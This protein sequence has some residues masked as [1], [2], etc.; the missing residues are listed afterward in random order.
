MKFVPRTTAPSSTNKYYL[1]AGKGG[2]NR[3]MEINKTTHSCLPNCCGLVHGRWME[4]QGQTD[5]N[6]Y[7]K[8]STGDACN[9]YKR[10]DGYKRGQEPKLG[11]IGCYSGGKKDAGHVL[12]VEEIKSN[13]D[14]VTSNSAY[15]GT[16]FFM[17]TL[18]KKS[19]Y[20]Y[21]SIH[22]FQGFIYNPVEFNTNNVTP[23]V[24]R[25]ETKDQLKVLTTELR[26]RTDHN[27]SA[28]ILGVAQKDGIYNYY[29]TFKD[30]KY[31]WYRIADDQWIANNGSWLEI[32]PKKESEEEKMKELI[33]KLEKENLELKQKNS[34]LEQE[35]EDSI[36]NQNN[37]KCVY[38]CLKS[39]NYNVKI[40]LKENECLYIN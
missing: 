12:F 4:S 22:K 34:I 27:T 32:Y 36:N 2:Y 11:A 19:G 35:L 20:K 30:D 9:Y 23:T 14:I 7:D 39:G 10:K 28:D 8:L 31:T 29:E 5:Y 37:Y 17:K 38:K 15:G 40:Y 25:D 13:G 24:E 33:E 6:K 21:S 3:A 1:K 18:T 26:V 16:R